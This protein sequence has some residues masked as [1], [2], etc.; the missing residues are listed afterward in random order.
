M[1]ISDW[2]VTALMLAA[3]PA[4]APFEAHEWGL[5]DVAGNNAQLRA[6]PPSVRPMAVRK[7]VLYF[8]L[9]A[10]AEE[11]LVN[12]QVEAGTPDATVIEHFPQATTVKAG[13]VIWADVRVKRGH[14][15]AAGYPRR[16]APVCDG[17]EECEATELAGYEAADSECLEFGGKRFNLLFYRTQGSTPDKLPL[18]LSMQGAALVAKNTGTQAIPGLLIRLHEENDRVVAV[19]SPPPPPR[20]ELTLP[21]L[22]KNGVQVSEVKQ[23]LHKMMLAAGLTEAESRAFARAWYPSFF[24]VSDAE[25]A[26][27]PTTRA[28]R[29][30]PKRDFVLYL[31]PS[32]AVE[33]VT[34]VVVTPN[35]T[36]LSR[37]MLVRVLVS[38][39]DAG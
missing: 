35:P 26:R 30:P 4:S 3:A 39:A 2:L 38:P 25:P 7:P 32:E 34:T 8:H 20:G 14:C 15:K 13:Q 22:P 6:G 10:E 16:D 21:P 36:K 17:L 12:V 37:F 18:Q 29:A 5:L 9:G 19:M 23:V 24:H 28:R 33:L 1:P 31:L 11:V 27:T